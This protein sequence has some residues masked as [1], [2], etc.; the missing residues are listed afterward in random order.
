MIALLLG[1]AF[2]A[3]FGVGPR[4]AGALD[5]PFT[6]ELG[7]G[8]S[9][10]LTPLPARAPWLSLGLG[11]MLYPELNG[12]LER[13]LTLNIKQDPLNI[14]ADTSP[15][16]HQLWL[17]A[18][19]DTAPLSLGRWE[20]RVGVHGGP[21]LFHTLDDLESLGRDP[22]EAPAGTVDQWHLAPL[23]GAH[24]DLIHGRVNARLSLDRA[25]W[26]EQFL[27]LEE[28]RGPWWLGMELLLWR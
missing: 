25:R 6:V 15:V 13:P 23:L 3:D 22:S 12:G 16:A 19:L 27:D 17:T 18:Q 1:T 21:A 24:A 28:R 14:S 10:V 11:G 20:S 26:T 9:A 7:V 5:D 4:L 2:A 8:A